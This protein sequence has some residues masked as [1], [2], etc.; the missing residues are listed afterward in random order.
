[1]KIDTQ[2]IKLARRLR[3][4]SM[5]D[6]CRRMGSDAV[7]KMAISKIE[8]GIMN[9][10]PR[11]LEAI[12][13]ACEVPVNYFYQQDIQI[14]KMDFRFSEGITP[15]KAEAIRSQV[16]AA[17]INYAV[18]NSCQLSPVEFVNP[19][20]RT[21]LR[22]YADAEK[23]ATRLRNKWNIGQQPIFS[24]YELLQGYG[25]HVIELEIDD[26]KVDGI[27]TFVNGKTPI[28]VVN[29]LKHKTT[30][31]KRFTALHELAHLLFRLRPLSENE[32]EA[33]QAALP[34]LP[35]KVTMKRADTERLCNLFASA[36]LLPDKAV[37]RR[38]GQ[39][40]YDID[41]QE[42]ISIRKM[43]GISIAATVH[44]LH[45]LRIIPDTLYDH[46]YDDII[47]PNYMEQGWGSFPIMEHAE[48]Q[49]L[50]KIRIKETQL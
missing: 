43:Y 8:R 31:R 3:C 46:Y 35:Y 49:M 41:M 32:H 40:R 34:S 19:M 20:A 21:T 27:A 29:T 18:V 12:A 24:V 48:I 37:T 1:M 22:T 26:Q 5:D 23:A 42:L 39:S 36:M 6:L 38:I 45:D 7:S 17:I 47:K 14:G 50:L 33:Y 10:S 15:R 11:T 30:E 13:Y 4:Y 16:T 9:P 44:R 25:I 28:V 2:K